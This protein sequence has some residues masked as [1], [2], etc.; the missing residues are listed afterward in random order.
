MIF[1][2]FNGNMFTISLLLCPIFCAIFSYFGLKFL[3]KFLNRHE[4]FQP[5]RDDGPKTH[6]K[7]TKTPTM[8]GI[9]LFLSTFLGILLFSDI[10][11]PEN[12]ILLFLITIFAGIGLAD[13]I[14]KVFY[15]NTHGFTGSKKLILQ[16]FLTSI[17]VLFLVYYDGT[18]LDHGIFIPIIDYELKFGIFM[19]IIYVFL[20]CGSANATNITDGLDTLLS[21]SVVMILLIF[22]YICVLAFKGYPFPVSLDLWTFCNVMIVSLAA[23]STFSVFIYFNKNPAKIFMGDVGSLM[24]GALLCYL[25]II[26][27][28]EFFYGIMA[29]LFI[30]EIMSSV[31]Q[32]A[33]FKITHGKRLFLMA[34]FHHNLEQHGFSEKTVVNILTIFTIVCCFTSYFLFTLNYN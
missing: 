12:I 30:I 26:M 15:K 13:D 25:A 5:I 1:Y 16:L 8:G 9:V 22:Y 23:F 11:I 27:K 31:M 34:P 32:V 29:L 2:L 19:P 24:I 28:I 4:E 3:I 7:K 14:I 33:Y 18:Y 6:L 10:T 17:L 20:I 21:K